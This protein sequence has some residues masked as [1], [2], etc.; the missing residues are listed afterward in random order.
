MTKS[1]HIVIGTAGHVDHG[2][3]SL[4]LALTGID[5][6]RLAEEKRRGITIVNGYAHFD[7]GNGERASI[8]DVPGH[9]R[10]IRHML[11]G[12]G[13]IDLALLVVAADDGIMPQTIEH[14]HIIRLLGI[15]R[16]VIAITK[17]DL[18]PDQEWLSLLASSILELTSE[19]FEI[20]PPL[21]QVSVVTG[22]GLTELKEVLIQAALAVPPKVLQGRFRLPVDRVFTMTGFGTVVTGT[23]LE[24]SVVAGQPAVTYPLE[25]ETKIRQ[26]QVH[27]QIVDTAWPGQRTALNLSN[28]KKDDL[29][30]GDVIATPGSLVP[31][32]MLDAVFEMLP[33]S[34]FQKPSDLKNGRLVKLHLAS[35]ELTAKMILIDQNRISPG[36]KAY[37]QFRLVESAVARKGDRFVVR[38]PSPPLTIGGGEILDAA[39]LKRRPKPSVVTV[40]QT[41]ELG[42]HIQRVE[43]A[44]R[45]RPGQFE[46]FAETI[47]RADL[48]RGLARNEAN[49]LAKRK[50]LYLLAA[51]VYIHAQEKEALTGKLQSFLTDY[52]RS[53]PF[54]PG[55]NL[56]EVRLKFL[57]NASPTAAEA[58]INLLVQEK[59][60][61]REG[62]FLRLS[63]FEP[64]VDES[65]NKHADLLENAYLSYG[66]SPLATSAVCPETD[67]DLVR[68]RKA[69]FLS[70]V[71]SGR[72]VKLDDLYHI[73]KDHL[74]KAFSIFT[75]LSAEGPVQIGQF[76]D[77]LNTSRKVAL[78]L[79][80]SF[81]R[82][83]R[84][85]KSGDGRLPRG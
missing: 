3:T 6:D 16:A 13:S 12:T 60:V 22:Q 61:V 64:K 35:R 80:N 10:F 11:A 72:L 54:S 31:S 46:P 84:T 7:L 53:N 21:V 40:F 26:V 68:R 34:Y 15:K 33:K 20:P 57:A 55:A 45:E 76:R 44:V 9:E 50:V 47:K 4:V 66:F 74:D 38:L 75:T 43:L 24:G 42:G 71:R 67:P 83:G 63:T 1:R 58:F 77:A 41:K 78:A 28:L 27:S 49:A 36:A 73:H 18:F 56:E 30:R 17:C 19:A 14:L 70:L 2:K 82:S 69:A 32:M 23:L 51:D 39:P 29:R 62:A 8:V 52:H 59:K 25:L 81:D 85:I 37:V 79:L 65:A 48:D 5:A